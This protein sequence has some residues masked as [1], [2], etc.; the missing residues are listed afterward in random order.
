MSTPTTDEHFSAHGSKCRPLPQPR[1][2][3]I[4]D[5]D[6]KLIKSRQYCHGFRRVL[7]KLSAIVSQVS[8]ARDRFVDCIPLIGL[9]YSF[10]ILSAQFI[11]DDWMFKVK[12]LNG[13]WV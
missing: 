8:C 12:R 4:A 11:C 2:A 5:G 13:L 3:T 10:Q 6:N 1:S 7:S 9:P